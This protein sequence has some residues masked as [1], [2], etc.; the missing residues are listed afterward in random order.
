MNTTAL[1]FSRSSSVYDTTWLYPPGDLEAYLLER[2]RLEAFADARNVY[3][4]GLFQRFASNAEYHFAWNSKR[5]LPATVTVSFKGRLRA[6]LNEN[7]PIYSESGEDQSNKIS[8]PIQNTNEETRLR[9]MISNPSAPCALQLQL[10]KDN[11]YDEMHVSKDGQHNEKPERFNPTVNGHLPHEARLPEAR[12]KPLH[13]RNGIWDFGREMFGRIETRGN[14]VP[15]LSVGESEEEA[16]N[17]KPEAQEQNISWKEASAIK[18]EG[19]THM[20][21]NRLAFRYVRSTKPVVALEEALPLELKGLIQAES[22][23]PNQ[24]YSASAETL[25]LCMRELLVDGIK[26]DRLPWAGDLYIAI[27]GNAVTWNEPEV[28]RRTLVALAPPEP[29]RSHVNGIVDYSLQWLLSLE[30]YGFLWNDLTTLEQLWPISWRIL[31]TL[32]GSRDETKLLQ[33]RP[34]DWLFIDWIQHERRGSLQML[35]LA[36]LQATARIASSLNK[37]NE[38]AQIEE[39]AEQLKK[40]IIKNLWCKKQRHW[41]ESKNG[42][43][44]RHVNALAIFAGLQPAHENITDYARRVLVESKLPP[45]KTPYMKFFE[46]LALMEVNLRDA[47]LERIE[48][49]W[50]HALQRGLTTFPEAYDPEESYESMLAFYNRP[51]GR[52]LCHAWSA[53][54]SYLLTAGVLGIQ[55]S[56][57]NGQITVTTLP[58]SWQKIS[59]PYGKMQLLAESDKLA[60]SLTS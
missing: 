14:E 32:H 27:L 56:A 8:I 9:C 50:N 24:V 28:L 21:T 16:R 43:P 1:P 60:S 29:E 35:Y 52:S 20:M 30:R 3:H 25:R 19:E 11:L 7:P 48:N 59:C 6:Q 5:N 4:P 31:Q 10:S 40:A 15:P 42:K 51:F 37:P 55:S 17:D 38:V 46:L 49:Y 47:A 22:Q 53:G 57:S 36:G 33:P 2:M 18:S 12:I 34:Q 26:R 58:N 45:V 23:W 39:R 44:S 13:Q 41:L 54:P